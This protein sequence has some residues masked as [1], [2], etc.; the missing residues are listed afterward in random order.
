[1]A[2]PTKFTE[3]AQEAVVEAQRETERRRLSQFEPEVLLAALVV[4]HAILFLDDRDAGQAALRR[5]RVVVDCRCRRRGGGVVIII[6]AFGGGYR[7]RGDS[8]A[9][10]NP[11]HPV[12]VVV[13]PGTVIAA[14]I[15]GWVVDRGRVIAAWT[16]DTADPTDS[17]NSTYTANSTHASDS[18]NSAH[19]TNSADTTDPTMSADPTSPADSRP[20]T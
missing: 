8:H 1:M 17:T 10:R 6:V 9:D 3:K 16:T 7:N 5:A 13:A 18:A 19:P 2:A 12:I 15:W 14:V 11:P 4:R 20:R